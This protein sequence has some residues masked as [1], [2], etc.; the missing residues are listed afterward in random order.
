M[1]P[2]HRTILFIL[3]L[4]VSPAVS[5]GEASGWLRPGAGASVSG[6]QA[7][8]EAHAWVLLTN[9]GQ[10]SVILAHLPPRH[11]AVHGGLPGLAR[12]SRTL[13]QMPAGL[14]AS[15]RR[16][17]MVFDGDPR[18]VMSIQASPTPIA[19]IWRDDPEGRLEPHPPLPSRG[20]LAGLAFGGD[21]LAALL[22]DETGATLLE[23]EGGSWNERA[24]PDDAGGE[25]G[26]WALLGDETGLVLIRGHKDGSAWWGRD[27]GGGWR[28]AT[29]RL[30]PD[31]LPVGLF[32]GRI[33]LI[34]P[35]TGE[36]TRAVL[37]ADASGVE[38]IATIAM[39][40]SEAS[41]GVGVAVLPDQGGRIA[42]V[43][44]EAIE[45]RPG[46]AHRIREVSLATGRT[47]ADGPVERVMPVSA[48]EFRLLAAWLIMVLVV[49]LFIVLRPI[50]DRT[51][52]VLPEGLA[53]AGPGRRFAATVID[54]AV[55][56][57]PI[58]RVWGVSVPDIL[59][60]GILLAP[61]EDWT[62]MPAVLGMGAVYGTLMEALF[63]G[64]IG[65]LVLG[66]RV[67]RAAGIAP[68]RVRWVGMPGCF[69]RNLIKWVLPPVA[70]L[71]ALD[72]SGRHRGDLV[73]R[74]V[75]VIRVEP[76]EPG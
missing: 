50:D 33:I 74:A 73:A 9:P 67:I 6:D 76:D 56:A 70:A 23:L 14:A 37:L 66:C 29:G 47:L 54:L 12:L 41:S 38:P 48:R 58:A 13:E 43:W 2:T 72:P 57:I 49:S 35:G 40:G 62:A 64:T 17:F 45:A 36:A 61:G 7:V 39:P 69:G 31:A 46:F 19:G 11:A 3:A 16:V 18:R 8:I 34:G 15:G 68:G 59:T 30:P 28:G 22:V 32:R 25:H 51:P 71:A 44:G 1:T 4:L 65:K 55:C 5:R 53:L 27:E 63:G 52:V 24:L 60:G 21:R 10:E 42:L 75:V 26:G 20:R